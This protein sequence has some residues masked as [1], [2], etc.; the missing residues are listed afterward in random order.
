MAR[1]ARLAGALL[2]ETRRSYYLVGNTKRP[3]DF[4]A[5]GFVPPDSID[6]VARPYTALTALNEIA[7]EPPWLA[8]DVE[9]EAL[10]KLLSECFLITRNGSVSDRLWRLVAGLRDEDDDGEQTPVTAIDARWLAG[11]PKPIWDVVR[12]CVLRCT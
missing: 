8:I 7:L 5:R 1:V 11:M 2:A 6:A 4:A 3:C 10:P 9:G 12:D